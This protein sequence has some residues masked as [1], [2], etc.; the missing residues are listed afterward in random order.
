MLK[1]C[2]AMATIAVKD[3]EAARQFYEG[4]LGLDTVASEPGML[5]LRSGDSTVMVYESAFAGTNR[6]VLHA[7]SA[8]RVRRLIVGSKRT[9]GLE[10]PVR[11]LR[12][13]TN[14]QAVQ[15]L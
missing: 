9:S 10:V 15:E 11:P 12:F 13:S 5:I 8:I 1:Q 2:N 14:A 6:A 4:Q 3:V 7:A